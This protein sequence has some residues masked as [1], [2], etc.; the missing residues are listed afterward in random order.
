MSNS[1]DNV[2]CDERKRVRDGELKE[3]RDRWRA[4]KDVKVI[5]ESKEWR[6][7]MNNRWSEKQRRKSKCG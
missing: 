4:R 5:R 1:R 3:S 2:G 7:E 6:W